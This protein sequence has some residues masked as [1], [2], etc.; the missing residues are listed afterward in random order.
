MRS[1]FLDFALKIAY[2]FFTE[3][4]GE[5]A[6]IKSRLGS[7]WPGPGI[8]FF[9]KAYLNLGALD[10]RLFPGFLESDS[11]LLTWTKLIWFDTFSFSGTTCKWD[12]FLKNLVASTS[13]PL[14]SLRSNI[15]FYAFSFMIPTCIRSFEL[16]LLL[17]YSSPV[18]PRN[19]STFEAN[20]DDFRYL[21][22][23]FNII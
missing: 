5:S 8:V 18:P 23:S 13:S 21:S 22:I 9:S 12:Y 14:K 4:K 19:L 16:L 6:A 11:W 10:F 20:I 3:L 7:Y 2:P 15:V 17:C 1:R